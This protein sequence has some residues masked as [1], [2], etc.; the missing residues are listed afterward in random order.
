M[1]LNSKQIRPLKTELA[2]TQTGAVHKVC[3]A[4]RGAEMDL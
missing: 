2:S 1:K 4:L 3:H